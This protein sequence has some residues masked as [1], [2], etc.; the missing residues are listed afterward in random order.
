MEQYARMLMAR[1]QAVD[2]LEA[3][4][5]NLAQCWQE[6]RDNS[7]QGFAAADAAKAMAYQRLLVQRRDECA[8]AVETAEQRVNVAL[9]GMI[10]ARQQREIV[11]K[12]FEKQKARHERELARGEQK[13]L[14]ELA[15]GRRSRSIFA[16]KAEETS[17]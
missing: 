2:A 17:V 13:F 4:R 5:R 12:C 10:Q 16:W 6:W 7:A 9:Q 15:A 8:L 3:V 14:D 11:D 1:L